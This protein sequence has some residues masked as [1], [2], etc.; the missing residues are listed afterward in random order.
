MPEFGLE[1]RQRAAAR[2]LQV[3]AHGV[4]HEVM[5]PNMRRVE[6]LRV[7][8][9]DCVGLLLFQHFAEHVYLGS[10][11][12]RVILAVVEIDV[13][14]TPGRVD[15]MQIETQHFARRFQFAQTAG[16]LARIASQGDGASW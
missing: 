6:I 13:V 12:L 8:G 14:K 3:V 1:K 10:P 9:K 7:G 2:P 15:E 5:G 11:F 16:A 4:H